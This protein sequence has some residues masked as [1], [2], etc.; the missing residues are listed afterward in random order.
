MVAHARTT[1]EIIKT[2]GERCP[3]ALVNNLQEKAD[4]IVMLD[5]EGGKG[6][7]QHKNKIVASSGPPA[8]PSSASPRFRLAAACRGLVKP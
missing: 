5:H 4:F 6:L 1:A 2:F 7:L 3:G 8:I